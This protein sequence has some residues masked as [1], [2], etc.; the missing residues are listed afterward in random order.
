MKIWFEISNSP[1]VNMWYDIIKDLEYS[2]HAVVITSRP[3]ANTIQIL[4]QKGLKHTVIGDHYGKSFIKKIFGFP[5]RIL[6]LWNHLRHKQINL[7]IS[8]SSFHSPLVAF[9][10]GIPSIYTNDNEHAFGNIPAFLFASK[11]L[12]PENM[13]QNKVLHF[14]RKKTQIYPGIKEGIYL[15]RLSED[16]LK[17][18][19]QGNHDNFRVFIRPEPSTAQYYDGKENFMDELLNELTDR[20]AVTV[21]ARNQSQF[22]HYNSA[23]FP[24]LHVPSIPISFVDIASSCSYFIGAGGSMTREMAMV[25]VPTVSVYQDKLLEVDKALIESGQLVHEPELTFEKLITIVK[26]FNS[27][28]DKTILM[29]KGKAAYEL[30]MQTIGKYNIQNQSV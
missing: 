27:T 29:Q 10:L 22:D 13:K 7:A 23:K 15:W 30:F 18:R 21:L 19:L 25:G 12:I 8:Q 4:D 1:H 24:K 28:T 17:K 2:G 16:I 11:I 9:L 14:L 6:Q 26:E 5:V 20:E 3:L